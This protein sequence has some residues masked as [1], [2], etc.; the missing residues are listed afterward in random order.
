M[1]ASVVEDAAEVI[2]RVFDE[3]DRRDPR[4][5]RR[6]VALVDGNRHQIDCIEAQAERP[7]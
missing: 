4:H 1:T 3:A 6:W 7:R 2:G 5:E